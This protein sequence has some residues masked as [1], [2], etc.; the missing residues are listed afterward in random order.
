MTT[1]APVKTNYLDVPGAKVYYEVRGSGPVLLCMPGGPA[2][3]SAF[4][5]IAEQLAGDYTVVTYDPRDLSHSQADAPTPTDRVVETYADDVHRLLQAVT[6]EPASILASSGGATIVLELIRRHPEQLRTVI[7]HEPPSPSF[8]PDPST[9]RSEMD[10]IVATFKSGG[11]GP[12]MQKFMAHTRIREGGPPPQQGAPTPEQ[13]EAQARF[14]RNMEYWFGYY[15]QGVASYEPDIAALKASSVR[16][17]PGVGE[18]S[19]GQRAN[20][21]GLGLARLLGAQ[22]V[23][24]PG[25]HGGFESH[26]EPFA[27]KLREV[28]GS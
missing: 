24:F 16:I 14:M 20:D 18:E 21:G 26:A 15:F 12:T 9:A 5:R 4:G 25:A 2:D 6:K 23:I 19:R 1:A 28:L 7:A 27:A 10:D 11:L 17:V 22:A 8:Q 3:A 13:R